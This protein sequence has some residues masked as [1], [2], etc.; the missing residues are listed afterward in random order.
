MD[1]FLQNP[2]NLIFGGVFGLYPQNEI[3]SLKS[4]SVSVLPLRHPNFMRSFTKLVS[5]V[6]KKT[7]L[8]TD[9]LTQW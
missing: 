8:P 2:K 3:L 5:D 1:Y 4:S 7:R 6:L 9:I